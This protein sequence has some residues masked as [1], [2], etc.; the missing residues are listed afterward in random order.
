MPQVIE[1]IDKIAINEPRLLGQ[2]GR[3]FLE[4]R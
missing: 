1:H 4:S 2:M 3:R